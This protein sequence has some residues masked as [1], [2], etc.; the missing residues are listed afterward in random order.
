MLPTLAQPPTLTD[1]RHTPVTGRVQTFLDSQRGLTSFYAAEGKQIAATWTDLGLGDSRPQSPMLVPRAA[2]AMEDELCATT[3]ITPPDKH[4]APPRHSS[5]STAKPLPTPKRISHSKIVPPRQIKSRN[6]GDAQLEPVDQDLTPDNESERSKRLAQRRNRRQARQAA[7]NAADEDAISEAASSQGDA[8]QPKKKRQKIVPKSIPKKA[9][10]APA[11]LLM[12]T[13]SGQN[14]GKSRLTMKPSTSVGVFNKGKASAKIQTKPQRAGGPGPDIVFSE[15]A[16]LNKTRPTCSEDGTSGDDSDDSA[17]HSDYSIMERANHRNV[18]S[19]SQLPDNRTSSKRVPAAHNSVGGNTLPLTG[20]VR[21]DS[22]PWDVEEQPA[23]SRDSKNT[24][25]RRSSLPSLPSKPKTAVVG[26][27]QCSWSSKLRKP[28]TSQGVSSL[29][30]PPK[31]SIEKRQTTSTY[32]SATRVSVEPPVAPSLPPDG[33]T[34]PI[35]SVTPDKIVWASPR[36]YTDHLGSP[37]NRALSLSD[38]SH[39]YMH[40]PHI[41]LS[42]CHSPTNSMELPL[43]GGRFETDFTDA[44]G[45]YEECLLGVPNHHEPPSFNYHGHDARHMLLLDTDR[46]PLDWNEI[47][48]ECGLLLDESHDPHDEQEG[49]EYGTYG[50]CGYEGGSSYPPTGEDFGR[51]GFREGVYAEHEEGVEYGLSEVLDGTGIDEQGLCWAVAEEDGQLGPLPGELGFNDPALID[52]D[53]DA[54]F[55][56]RTEEPAPS[57]V[58]IITET[59][60]ENDLMKSISNHWGTA[61]RLY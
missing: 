30:L 17:A 3:H 20:S 52:E 38:M 39:D 56:D 7:M 10:V 54:A 9:K 1:H 14:M 4:G 44:D 48:S 31:P 8:S 32:F 46:G 25:P 5:H 16:F 13:F 12:Q 37:E 22:P 26:V 45:G 23:L 18:E 15:S 49:A 36:S 53:D 51:E 50:Y 41:P 35:T 47:G 57:L 11:L 59:S 2:A 55:E 28:E 29:P 33:E 6:S 19:V 61:H 40:T 42:S 24:S 58:R 21:E 27:S 34:D 43:H 60:L